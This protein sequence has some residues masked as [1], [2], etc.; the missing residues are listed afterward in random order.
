[1]RKL[2]R[3]MMLGAMTAVMTTA[4]L[5]S[6]SSAGV[7]A[8]PAAPLTIVKTVSGPVPAGTTFT[9]N[10]H[11]PDGNIDTGLDG[12]GAAAITATDAT[13]TFDAAGQP[14]S[15]DIIGFDDQGTCTV[16]ETASGGAA[17]V[18]YSCTG[19]IPE[20][21]N[22]SNGFGGIAAEQIAPV[23][24]DPCEAAGPQAAPMVVLIVEPDQD[25]T[26][27]VHNTFADPAPTPAAQV[28][29]QPAFTG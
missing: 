28:V 1:V 20:P 4:V 29:I 24:T 19:T 3:V 23:P 6:G 25:A 13:V 11:C 26:V 15:P 10:L 12:A 5:V 2:L 14:T 18:T 8:G 16:T 27:T 21:S 9:V 17:S 7:L 22:A